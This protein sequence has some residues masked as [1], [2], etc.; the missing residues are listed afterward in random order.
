MARRVADLALMLSIVA[1]PDPQSPSPRIVPGGRQ[2]IG[3]ANPGWQPIEAAAN[4]I[5]ELL[6]I[7]L[8]S[9]TSM[10]IRRL[11]AGRK[12][13][14]EDLAA[15]TGVDQSRVAKIEN[16]SPRVTLDA[17]VILLF[18]LGGMLSDLTG[19]LMDDHLSRVPVSKIAKSSTCRDPADIGSLGKKS[20]GKGKQA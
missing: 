8:K 15:L 2:D 12:M 20:E 1:G 18:A 17:M 4:P 16:C 9:T 3:S 14:Q 11:R 19:P 13:T 5:A 6:L 7:D 10:A